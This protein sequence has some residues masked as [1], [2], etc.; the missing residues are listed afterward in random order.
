MQY[1]QEEAFVS[2]TVASTQFADQV[3]A[4]MLAVQA[5]NQQQFQHLS[6]ATE[7][8]ANNSRHIMMVI[9]N[10]AAEKD[11]EIR[12]LQ[13]DSKT[14]K[15]ELVNL[16]KELKKSRDKDATDQE[17]KMQQFFDVAVQKAKDTANPI[18]LLSELKELAQSV[19]EGNTLEELRV[20]QSAPP[21][22]AGEGPSTRPFD[23]K[24][25]ELYN[26]DA[27]SMGAVGG[28]GRGG[29]GRAGGRGGAKS[30]PGSRSDTS[31][32]DRDAKPPCK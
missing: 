21:K 8:L 27:D 13:K 17:K 16:R 26:S 30:P 20:G 15:R 25:W 18:Q 28:A 10:F 2:L 29:G 11:T 1:L 24:D 12:R 32:D 14:T 19:K 22:N 31:S 4:A 5:T 7:K 6:A 9:D 3:A 23:V